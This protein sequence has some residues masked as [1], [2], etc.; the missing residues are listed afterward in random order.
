MPKWVIAKVVD[1][2]NEKK[3]AVAGSK[4]LLLGLAY[5][6]D[7]DD[8]RESPTVELMEILDSKGATV[9]YS[10]PHISKFP[11]MRKHYFELSSV[12]LSPATVASYDCV[13]IATNHSTFDYA[14]IQKNAKIIVDTR[15][16]YDSSS[17]NVIN[18]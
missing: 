16:V 2:L 9:A 6:K 18:A 12:E 8:I 5:K 13:I 10:D 17:K 1:A 3:Q 4:I 11:H 15:G 7:V 14:M